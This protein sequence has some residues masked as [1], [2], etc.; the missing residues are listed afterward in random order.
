L[1]GDLIEE[2]IGIMHV[3]GREITSD[4]PNRGENF[5]QE[6]YWKEMVNKTMDL[7]GPIMMTRY[8]Q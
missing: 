6:E 8:Y 7:G 4:W 5:R 2:F 3:I 1:Q